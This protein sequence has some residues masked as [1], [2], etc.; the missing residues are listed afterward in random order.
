MKTMKRLTAVAMA[1]GIMGIAVPLACAQSTTPIGKCP[2]GV[3]KISQP[4]CTDTKDFSTGYMLPATPSTLPERIG[5]CP[6]GSATPDCTDIKG[7]GAS[8]QAWKLEDPYKDTASAFGQSPAWP[9][10]NGTGTLCPKCG[11]G[12]SRDAGIK[13]LERQP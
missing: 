2:P 5:L 9:E 7:F 3:I 11:K 1:L 10:D 6:S 8:K 13:S 12:F 4:T